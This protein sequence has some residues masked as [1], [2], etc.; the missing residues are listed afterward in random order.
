MPGAIL[1]SEKTAVSKT[2]ILYP[3]GAYVTVWHKQ[4]VSAVRKKWG[5]VTKND[6]SG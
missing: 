2:G 6:R 1:G 5:K 3:Q 4:R